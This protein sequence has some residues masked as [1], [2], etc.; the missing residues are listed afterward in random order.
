VIVGAGVGSSVVFGVG[1]REHHTF[2]DAD[3]ALTGT[4]DWGAYAVDETPV[5]HGAGVET[6]TTDA[7]EAYARFPK[8]DPMRY[9]DGLLPG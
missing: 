2:R 3:G 8:A 4:P 7:Q 9:R 6:Q 1:A 5:R